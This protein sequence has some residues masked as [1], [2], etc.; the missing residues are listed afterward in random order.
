MDGSVSLIRSSS[1]GKG[2]RSFR[3]LTESIRFCRTQITSVQ[4]SLVLFSVSLAITIDIEKLECISSAG[5][6]T[7]L[8]AEQYLEDNDCEQIKVI[9]ANE[10]IKEIL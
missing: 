5:L 7:I 4:K 8:E 10:A 6:R 2:T 9:N 3:G 1:F